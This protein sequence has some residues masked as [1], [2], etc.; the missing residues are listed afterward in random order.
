MQQRARKRPRQDHSEVGHHRVA[1]HSSAPPPGCSLQTWKLMH[2]IHFIQL[3]LSLANPRC[4][5]FESPRESVTIKVRTWRNCL[6][7]RSELSELFPKWCLGSETASMLRNPTTFQHILTMVQIDTK[8]T[9][10]GSLDNQMLQLLQSLLLFCQARH[11]AL[12][13]LMCPTF[14]MQRMAMA[15]TKLCQQTGERGKRKWLQEFS[16]NLRASLPIRCAAACQRP[17][18]AR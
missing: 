6:L 10:L 18:F 7:F 13:Q 16:L 14:H 5:I 17:I 12:L 3:R 1:L 15:S 8:C 2:R 9:V 11:G 4:W